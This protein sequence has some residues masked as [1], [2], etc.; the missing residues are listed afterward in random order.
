MGFK[1]PKFMFKKFCKRCEISFRPIGKF[2]SICKDC[3]QTNKG[4]TKLEDV[5]HAP[6]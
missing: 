5:I 2:Q 3:N 4:R 1:R 6:T